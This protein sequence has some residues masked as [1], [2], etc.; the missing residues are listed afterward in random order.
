MNSKR[1]IIEIEND[2]N[3]QKII[4]RENTKHIKKK[5]NNNSDY[6]EGDDD[7]E[8]NQVTNDEYYDVSKVNIEGKLSF[9]P[10]FFIIIFFMINFF[11]EIISTEDIA[12]NLKNFLAKERIKHEIFSKSILNCSKSTLARLLYEPKTWQT[13]ND[14]WKLYFKIIY[15]WLNDKKRLDKLKYNKKLPLTVKVES[16]NS[17]SSSFAN[18]SG[19]LDS[20]PAN[21]N[22]YDI[23]ETF[24][25]NKKS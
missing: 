25:S 12:Q 3:E 7:D 13:I 24:R 11:S 17:P 2:L 5:T 9:I 8:E 1:K 16:D 4:M 10:F 6:E 20:V 19:G 15:L 21:D 18:T 22:E 23:I 14:M